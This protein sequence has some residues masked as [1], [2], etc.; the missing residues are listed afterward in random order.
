MNR[1]FFVL[2]F[3]V[4]A[5]G[6]GGCAASHSADDVSPSVPAPVAASVVVV[7]TQLPVAPLPPTPSFP[8][9]QE[10]PQMEFVAPVQAVPTSFPDGVWPGPKP[11]P[12]LIAQ[13]TNEKDL[14]QI[15]EIIAHYKD[16]ELELQQRLG[17]SGEGTPQLNAL[18]KA[19]Q[20]R[21][22]AV[23]ALARND[24]MTAG[25]REQAMKMCL[26]Q[27][28]TPHNYIEEEKQLKRLQAAAG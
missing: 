2:P 20:N 19:C 6:L 13:T 11:W 14:R 22:E 9:P 8:T 25:F 3:G 4:L 23:R 1:V 12:Q 16:V 15:Q 18:D 24:E 27:V 28:G 17:T 21:I 5:L 26:A 10:T 7:P